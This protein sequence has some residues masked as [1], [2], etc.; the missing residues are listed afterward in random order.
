MKLEC[1]HWF[2]QNSLATVSVVLLLTGC[3]A[4]HLDFPLHE[5]PQVIGQGCSVT[6]VRASQFYGMGVTHYITLDGLNVVKLGSGDYTKLFV[7]Q[8]HHTV[9][10]TVLTGGLILVP[11]PPFVIGFPK[12]D[13]ELYKEVELECRP[14]EN[15]SYGIKNA[16]TFNEQKG[17]SLNSRISAGSSSWKVRL[18]F[19]PEPKIESPSFL[20]MP[21]S[22]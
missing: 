17:W 10:V 16:L 6:L 19:N 20:S 9:G 7:K 3:L 5:P 22:G 14:G 18:L 2:L 4:P 12:T 8:G 15:Y 21:V 1:Q 11:L 13:K